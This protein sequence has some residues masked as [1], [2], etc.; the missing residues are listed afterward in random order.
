MALMTQNTPYSLF[1][2]TD[3][4]ANHAVKWRQHYSPW[5]SDKMQNPQWTAQNLCATSHLICMT[6]TNQQELCNNQHSKYLHLKFYI[7][8]F[9]P[10]VMTHV[11]VRGQRQPVSWFS[12]SITWL[13]EFEL[14]FLDLAA[15]AFTR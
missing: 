1:P 7:F 6:D 2:S 5:V 10:G 8:L 4:P 13:P 11:E 9:G 15:N 3:Q 14:K 12:P